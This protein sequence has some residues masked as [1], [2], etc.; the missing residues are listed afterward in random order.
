MKLIAIDPGKSTGIAIFN[1]SVLSECG[2]LKFLSY[3][4]YTRNLFTACDIAKPQKMMVEK[5]VIY[6]LKNWKGDPNDLINLSVLVGICVAAGSPFCDV[7]LVEP[8]RWK[9][10]RPK[11]IDIEYTKKQ[12]YKVE[13]DVLNATTYNKK[14][15]HNMLDAIGIGLWCLDRR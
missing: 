5:P 11:N 12:L 6:P 2:V 1:N 14:D 9:G 8:R 13:L 10:S 15:R 3:R 7:D 4:D